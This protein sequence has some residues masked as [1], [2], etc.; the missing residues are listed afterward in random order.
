MKIDW[1][2]Y[3]ACSRLRR[4]FGV[5]FRRSWSQCGEDIIARYV[6]DILQIP[7]P[8]Y[9]DIG[10]HHP[11]HFS[12]THLFYSQ[13]S[14]GINIEPD[15]DLFVAFTQARPRDINL[16]VGIG[17]QSGEL[18]F[19]V[20]SVRTLNT[21]SEAEAHAIERQG[22]VRIE[23]VVTLPVVTVN[24]ILEDH[25]RT[26]IDFLS[27]DVEGLDLAILRTMDFDIVRPKVMCVETITYS[28]N[29]TGQK[30][31]DIESFMH[32]NGYFTYADTNINTLFVDRQI[33]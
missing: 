10:A 30:V 7:V 13:G 17:E 26:G 21:F 28:E 29:R 12:N 4:Q 24:S 22:S 32:G 23:R 14:R 18:D 31:K 8:T 15:P 5:N 3:R 9:L 2:A 1:L 16:N 25:C 27:L 33:W 19:Y 20:M 6:F 11:T